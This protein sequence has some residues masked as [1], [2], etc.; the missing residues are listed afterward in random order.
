[1]KKNQ[2]I[3]KFPDPIET[4]KNKYI[5][6]RDE[7][8]K[9]LFKHALKENDLWAVSLAAGRFA[10][11]NLEKIDGTDKTIEFFKNCIETQKKSY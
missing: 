10:S 5:K 11:M 6:I 7:I 4:K 8:E 1:M 3:L 9:I 2:N